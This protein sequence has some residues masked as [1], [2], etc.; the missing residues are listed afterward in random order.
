MHFSPPFSLITL[1]FI[2]SS[3]VFCF[4]SAAGVIIPTPSSVSAI[5][6]STLSSHTAVFNDAVIK[7]PQ[8]K[9]L[10]VPDALVVAAIFVVL[11]GGR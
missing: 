8:T 6:I 1:F 7:Q 11:L 2:R 10:P 4:I 3:G 5:C 9:L